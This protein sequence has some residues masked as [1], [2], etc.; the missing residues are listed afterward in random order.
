MKICGLCRPEDA[1]LAAGAG[2]THG[3]VIRVPGAARWRP[4][5]TARAVLDAGVGLRRVGVFVD[6][7]ADTV[8]A[9][10]EALGLDVAQLHG[11]E[12]PA[13]VESLR[14][15]GLEV[16]KVVKPADAGGLLEAASRYA[17]ADLLLVEGS[18]EAG[19][20]GVGARFDWRILEDVLESLGPA[21]RV[22]VAGGLT[23]A[24]VA[25]AV[26]RL[27]PSLVDVSSGVERAPGE[28]DG[29]RVRAFVARARAAEDEAAGATESGDPVRREE[30]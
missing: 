1:A 21:R 4:L 5:E 7:G 13:E 6:A 19:A 22:G 14:R 3:G 23:P 8:R 27:R 24:N 2:A 18:S 28:K 20:G 25:E 10:A 17:A 26:R 9:E 16:W 12:S 15:A 11:T 29:E 30:R